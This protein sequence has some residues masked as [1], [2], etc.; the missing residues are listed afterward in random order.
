MTERTGIV[1]RNQT[2]II[3]GMNIGSSGNQ[4]LHHISSTKTYKFKNKT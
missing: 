1:K 4:M 3:S 2:T